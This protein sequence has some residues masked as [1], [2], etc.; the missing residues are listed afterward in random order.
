M[1]KVVI[2]DHPLVHHKIGMIRRV[3]TGTKDFRR[4]TN[5]ISSLLTYEATKEL[6]LRDVKISSP[7]CD[8]TVKE[9]DEEKVVVV[10]ILRAGIGM[11]DGFLD[12]LP[13]AKVGYIGM[14][15]DEETILPQKYYFN[16]PKNMDNRQAFLVDPMLATGG[17]AIAA[18]DELKKMGVKKI[19]F[20]CILA[21]PEGLE[22]LSKAHPD[23]DIFIGEMDEKLNENKYIVPGLGDAGDRINGTV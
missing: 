15:R 16:M 19:S 6:E 8:T 18:I 7:I 11:V 14:Y 22:A 3:E 21:V 13:F 5:E 10:P 23:V 12:L 2:M 17:S 20:M 4:M 9:L 1:G